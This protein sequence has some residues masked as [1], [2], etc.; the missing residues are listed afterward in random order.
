MNGIRPAV[1]WRIG[2]TI[3]RNDSMSQAAP[4]AGVSAKAA[5][6]PR[7]ASSRVTAAAPGPPTDGR[8]LTVLMSPPLA[9][10][11]ER[12]GHELDHGAGR[13]GLPAPLSRLGDGRPQVPRLVRGHDE[14]FRCQRLDQLHLVVVDVLAE[15]LETRH[16]DG[17]L[18]EPDGRELRGP[19]VTDD[20]ARLAQMSLEL[21]AGQEVDAPAVRKGLAAR[22]AALDQDR[23]LAER[24]AAAQRV[25][26]TK[27]ARE[28]LARVTD[29]HE[30]HSTGPP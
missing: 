13:N 22:M 15:S 17:D 6:A 14:P 16:H 26:G 30:D 3:W 28:P 23:L 29:R 20:Q 11:L 25:D 24:A 1:E 27:Q 10:L 12:F 4:V 9:E 21:V 5:V 19:A 18:A 7:R 8:D 2:P